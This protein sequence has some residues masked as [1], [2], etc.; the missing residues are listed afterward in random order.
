MTKPDKNQKQNQLLIDTYESSTASIIEVD[1]KS[2]SATRESE[3]LPD[4]KAKSC[5]NL[6]DEIKWLENNTQKIHNENEIDE[7]SIEDL[8]LHHDHNTQ[9][10]FRH[11]NHFSIILQQLCQMRK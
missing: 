7:I 8:H 6:E 2:L 9:Q 4:I 11:M 1:E 3:Q 5:L 10:L